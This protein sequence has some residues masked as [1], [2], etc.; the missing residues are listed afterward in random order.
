MDVTLKNI[1]T[2]QSYF[3]DQY[4]SMLTTYKEAKSNSA[5]T[6]QTDAVTNKL[7]HAIESNRPR[8]KYPVTVP[9]HL[10]IFLKRILSTRL[11]DSIFRFISK[12]EMS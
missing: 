7:I 2:A 11:L 12:K 4:Q 5:F 6:K 9:A 10:F 3:K 1:D 8:P